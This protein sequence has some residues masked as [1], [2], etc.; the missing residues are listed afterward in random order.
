MTG[1]PQA[2]FDE[3]VAVMART[4]RDCPW[5]ASQTHRSLVTYLIE[6]TGELVDALEAGSDDD[7]VEEL[8]D[9]LLQVVFHSQ[10]GAEQGRFD[11]SEVIGGIV[12]KLVRRH[13]HV[14]AGEQV[15]EDMD[16]TWEQR[17]A[18]EKGRTSSL[19][20][21]AQSLSSIARATKAFHGRAVT[22]FRWTFPTN[23]S[24]PRSASRSSSSSPGPR[25][26]AST[27]TRP[28]V[29]PF[30]V[31]RGASLPPSEQDAIRARR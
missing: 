12:T 7:V 18:A 23:R 6:E 15:P 17:K 19:D 14:F 31:W 27:P 22:R 28:L 11:I 16:V 1:R 9:L 30:V 13:P 24:A 2:S 26:A 21:I 8:G 29:R 20:G 5:D 25:P 10:I 4:R 3:L